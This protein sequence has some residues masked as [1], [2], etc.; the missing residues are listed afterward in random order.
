M[1]EYHV[2]ISDS[3]RTGIDRQAA[4]EGRSGARIVEQAVALYVCLQKK[5]ERDGNVERLDKTVRE[6]MN[7]V[8]RT[9][10]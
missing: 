7:I 3:I 4:I 5:A 6:A 9:E 10:C 8:R 1:K 2:R